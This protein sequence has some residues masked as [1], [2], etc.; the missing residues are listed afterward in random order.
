MTTAELD[1]GVHGMERLVLAHPSGSRAEVYL[2]GGHV[3]S[4]RT[5][6]GVER[7][8]LSRAARFDARSA[9]RG[10]I[11]VIFP[12]FADRGRYAR[13]G[14]ARVLPWRFAGSGGG[15]DGSA[16]FVLEDSP[17]TRSAWPYA[18]RAELRV[19]LDERVLTV[20]LGIFNRDSAAF[21]FTAALHSYLRVVDVSRAR[22]LGLQ[23]T[24]YESGVEGVRDLVEGEP[25]LRVDG[26]VDRVYSDVRQSIRLRGGAAG[27]DM[28]LRKVGF[29]DVVLWNPGPDRARAISD[30]AVEEQREFICIEPAVVGRPVSLKPGEEWTGSQE[31]SIG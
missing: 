21:E 4:W 25:E 20:E 3:V 23:G 19:A 8:F 17:Q 18:F 30:M 9:I 5:A 15:A 10:G 29:P 28:T 16:V 27:E 7:L 2:H 11:P 26:E 31:L 6:D 1:H 22:V 24:R 12:Q 14:F 13:H